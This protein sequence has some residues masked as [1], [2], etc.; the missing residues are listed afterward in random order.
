MD[1]HSGRDLLHRQTKYCNCVPF[2]ELIGRP[3][4][5]SD[6]AGAPIFIYEE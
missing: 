3:A 5:R 2:P 4:N 6:Q 1:I